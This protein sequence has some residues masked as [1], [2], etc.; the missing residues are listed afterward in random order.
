[1]SI[2]V[3]LLIFFLSFK[4]ILLYAREMCH[5]DVN[6][7]QAQFVIGYGSLMQEKSKRE[8]L[9]DVGDN[10][11]IYLQGFKR[12]W[13]LHG[14]D[15]GFNTTYLAVLR[16]ANAR[17]NAVYFKLKKSDDIQ[18]YDERE[19][20]YCRTL[21]PLAHIKFLDSAETNSDSQFWIYTIK[22][23]EKQLASE[24][25]PIAQSYVDI[26]LTGCLELA[27]KYHKPD[28]A[29]DCIYLTDNWSVHWTNKK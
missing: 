22:E 1:M 8:E 20:G 18:A 6:H 14:S 2:K 21:V 16:H 3:L 9:A 10:Y 4:S 19:D 23:S 17:I 29:D 5:P 15:L 28:F 24:R 26:F 25:F 27:E 13:F 11:P 7:H 12:G